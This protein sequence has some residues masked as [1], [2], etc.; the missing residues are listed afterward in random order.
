MLMDDDV[1]QKRQKNRQNNGNKS[2]GDEGGGSVDSSSFS[3]ANA[4]AP[5]AGDSDLLHSSSHSGNYC[6]LRRR[7][8]AN[9]ANNS[10]EDEEYLIENLANLLNGHSAKD[11]S[12]KRN[13]DSSGVSSASDC[14]SV[15]GECYSPL[16]N[17][18]S[19]P[20]FAFSFPSPPNT[21][22]FT[23]PLENGLMDPAAIE[24]LLLN[25]RSTAGMEEEDV[26]VHHQQRQQQEQ[27]QHV[28]NCLDMDWYRAATTNRRLLMPYS[29]N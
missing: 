7:G 24:E 5:T 21:G 23:N 13:S 19:P 15:F 2:G 1:V 4:F 18:G 26:D 27:Q 6:G 22:L 20:S 14:G 17:L 3:C 9:G 10:D 29:N 16:V 8:C 12:S 25:T 28:L 11:S